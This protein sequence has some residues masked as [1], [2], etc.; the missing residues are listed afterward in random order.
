MKLNGS[1]PNLETETITI[2]DTVNSLTFMKFDQQSGI[3]F[4]QD[5]EATI[6]SGIATKS[7]ATTSVTSGKVYYLNTSGTWALADA[8][9]GEDP[10]SHMLGFAIITGTVSSR[11]IA[12]QGFV[13]IE[14]HGYNIG[15]PLYLSNTAGSITNTVPTGGYARIIGYAVSDSGIYFDPDKTWVQV[16]AP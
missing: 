6:F 12:L 7:I 16:G 5:D 14:E 10:A 15:A 8:N 1:S 9:N 13:F 2:E 11:G 4:T 3:L